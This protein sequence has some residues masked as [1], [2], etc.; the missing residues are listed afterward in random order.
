ML[1]MSYGLRDGIFVSANDVQR[2]LAC[3]CICPACRCALVAKKGSY[4][5]A[6][7]AHFDREDCGGWLETVV[8]QRAKALLVEEKKLM[9]PPVYRVPGKCIFPWRLVT[10]EK[11]DVEVTLGNGR[12]D[13]IGI[14]NGKPLAIEIAVSH[15]ISE[16]RIFEYRELGHAAVEIDIPPMKNANDDTIRSILTTT[17]LESRWICNRHI[18]SCKLWQLGQ[19]DYRL[20][21][22][23]LRRRYYTY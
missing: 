2:G 19:G 1:V 16:K 8:H 9:L 23:K 3:G 6:H 20:N 14:I 18:E 12:A 11:I 17:A 15:K 10:F 21:S 5:A 22:L 7:F 13:A 4:R